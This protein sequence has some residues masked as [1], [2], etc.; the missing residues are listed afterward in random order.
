[1]SLNYSFGFEHL[2]TLFALSLPS[3]ATAY[4]CVE[5]GGVGGDLRKGVGGRVSCPTRASPAHLLH[6][7]NCHGHCVLI[8]F[9]LWVLF[10]GGGGPTGSLTN[11]TS[12]RRKET[13]MTLLTRYMIHECH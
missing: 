5:A 7:P 8:F 4:V 3:L 9:L 6:R 11:A 13:M 10:R 1:M 12:P 2:K